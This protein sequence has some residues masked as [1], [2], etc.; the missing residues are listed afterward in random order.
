MTI[1]QQGNTEET[2]EVVEAQQEETTESSEESANE[3]K[4]T[5]QG[6]SP[7]ARKARLERQLEQLKKKHPELYPNQTSQK[8]EGKQSNGLDYGQKAFLVANGVKG[9]VETRLVQN[10]MRETGKTLEQVL[11]SKYFQAELKDIRDLQQSANAIPA[12]KRSGNMAS[13]N[14]DYWLTKDFKDVPADM[15][16]KVVNARLQKK[17]NKGVFYNS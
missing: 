1:E 11:E 8:S 3:G 16:A 9:D 13:D 4:E 17:E 10:V 14:V 15:K 5:R 7:E 12:G 6:E 2:E